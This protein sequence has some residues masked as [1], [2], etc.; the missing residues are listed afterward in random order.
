MHY[1]DKQ[2]LNPTKPIYSDFFL[3]QLSDGS[4]PT[5]NSEGIAKTT[6][7][8]SEIINNINLMLPALMEQI[9]AYS[10]NKTTT[11]AIH[12]NLELISFENDLTFIKTYCE[13]YV[14]RNNLE[15]L[16]YIITPHPTDSSIFAYLAMETK[17]IFMDRGLM[18]GDRVKNNSVIISHGELSRLLKKRQTKFDKK[19]GISSG[20][21]YSHEYIDKVSNCKSGYVH[22]LNLIR[23][24]HEMLGI[25]LT[26]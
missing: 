7:I 25:E 17:R 18:K 4:S 5:L 16:D 14:T 1:I 11:T 6:E 13:A 26:V 3:A 9:N 2:M 12:N 15:Y 8:C 20:F 23:E 24:L 10:N 21:A 19:T 22:M